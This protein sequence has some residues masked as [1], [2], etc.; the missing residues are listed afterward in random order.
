MTLIRALFP[1]AD[2]TA[3]RHLF[4]RAADYIDLETGEVPSDAT[5]AD[6]FA[7]APFATEPADTVKLGLFSGGRL[8]AI[9]DLAFGFPDQGDAFIGLL[10]IA[11]DRRGHGL[12]HLFVDHIA[13]VARA[14]QARRL[15]IAVLEA[16]PKARAFWAREGFVQVLTSPPTQMGRRIHI[17]HRM[18]RRL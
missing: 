10:L 13:D 6:F 1:D 11:A 12:G 17:R 9:A 18:E 4:D 3:V 14:R 15:F 7:P 2:A 16:N 8:D 5:V